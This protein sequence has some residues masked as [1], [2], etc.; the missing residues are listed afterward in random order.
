M[1]CRIHP[2]P[3]DASHPL[4]AA[5]VA[6][7]RAVTLSL[8][9]HDDFHAD[10][11]TWRVRLF[12]NRDTLTRA[13]VALPADVEPDRCEPTDALGYA[14]AEFPLREDTAT[15]A[16]YVGV[17]PDARCRGVGAAL[18][19]TILAARGE[20]TILQAWTPSPAV[21]PND[22]RATIAT[23]GGAIDGQD[24]AAR[25]LVARGFVLEQ[26]ERYS[27]LDLD[28][29]GLAEL[30]AAFAS[31]AADAAGVDYA[32]V[33]WHG[34]TPDGLR[35]DVA[36]ATRRFTTDV[37]SG[38]LEVEEGDWDAERVADVDARVE[39]SG[40]DAVSAAVRHLPSGQLVALTQLAWSRR[41]PAGISQW[42]TVVQP[43]HRGHR[44]GQ[45]VKAANLLQALH[46]NPDAARVHTWNALENT[47][48]L[49]IN[50]R[51]GF[52]VLGMEGAWQL[53]L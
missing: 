47:H 2:I 18:F 36:A 48:M 14:S 9:D 32:L 34:A 46:A 53:R 22:P 40:R 38:G 3:D 5:L 49:A 39:A 51:L 26:I 33:Q 4:L 10:L 11:A 24:A 42:I 25:W 12:V 15:L 50:D 28:R 8:F 41:N 35:A 20:R 44:L 30:L 52:V 23:S 17:R 29:P 13:W 1:E 43:A 19:E 7:D 31:S 6:A 21:A 45:W 16:C 27:C 37:P